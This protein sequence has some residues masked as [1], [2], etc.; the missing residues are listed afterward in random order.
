MD[1]ISSKLQAHYQ[2]TFKAYGMTSKGVD[3]GDDTAKLELRY[4][5]MLAVITGQTLAQ[6]TLLDVGCG[7]AGLF[8]YAKTHGYELDYTGIDVAK[9]MID[10]ATLVHRNAKLIHSDILDPSFTNQYDYVV[11]NG[12][13]TQKLDVPALEMDQFAAKLIRK[14]FNSCKVGMAFNVMS[15]KVNFFS[16]NLYYRNPS[17]MLA[18]CMSELS[19]RVMLDHSYPLYEYTVYIYKDKE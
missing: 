3:W 8:E 11:C 15:T 14:I 17:E 13:L 5:K 10:E 1:K 9:N 18:W 2:E 16:N 4:S 7:Y 12:I 19:P 6:P